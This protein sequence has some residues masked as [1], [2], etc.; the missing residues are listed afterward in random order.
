MILGIGLDLIELERIEKLMTRQKRFAERILTFNEIHKFEK[1]QGNRK[2][3]Y[4]AGRFAAKEAV[5]KALGSGIGEELS[6]QDI[7]VT[8]DVSGRPKLVVKN[9]LDKTF[10]LSITHT[11]SYAAAQVVVEETGK[12]ESSSS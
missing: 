5:S 11:K 9:I 6:F 1:L 8:N 3:E 10:H 12:N 2:I 4:L 7:E